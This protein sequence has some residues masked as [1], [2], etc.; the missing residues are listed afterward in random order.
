MRPI[1][2]TAGS[3]DALHIGHLELLKTCREYAGRTGSVVV[4]VNTSEF[5]KQFKGVDTVFSLEDR[6]DL[7]K[8]IR[9]VDRVVVNDSQ[10]LK[11]L[12]LKI[13]PD[14]LLIGD[15]WAPPKDY[16]AQ[17]QASPKWLENHS[18]ELVYV[19]RTTGM[20]TTKIKERVKYEL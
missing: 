15:D 5:V 13:K 6:I 19:P 20:S 4:S 11:P 17:I 9:Y 7:L 14:Y 12:L 8:A 10:D 2:F 18:I 3:F 1:I 16:H